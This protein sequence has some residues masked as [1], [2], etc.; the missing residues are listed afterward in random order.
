MSERCVFCDAASVDMPCLESPDGR[1]AMA[2]ADESYHPV[3]AL[4]VR[5]VQIVKGNDWYAGMQGQEFEV[6]R[7][8]RSYMLRSDYD[9]VS[10]LG[11][12]RGILFDDSKVVRSRILGP[13]YGRCPNCKNRTLGQDGNCHIE[14]CS[15]KPNRNSASCL[16]A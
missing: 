6:Y 12:V 16:Q 3:E 14:A 7:G 9:A 2:E 15:Y 10:G 8:P 13:E 5:I 11:P 1:H 4:P